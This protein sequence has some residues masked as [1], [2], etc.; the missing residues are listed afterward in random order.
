MF[1]FFAVLAGASLMALGLWMRSQGLQSQAW[2]ST[3]GTVT[4]H[5]LDESDLENMRPI[6]AYEYVVKSKHYVGWRVSYS[7]Y[8]ASKKAMQAYIAPYPLGSKVKVFYDP[9]CPGR[10]VLDNRPSQDWLFW[11]SAGVAFL[12]GA[13]FLM[14][15]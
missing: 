12:I 10:A 8:G 14:G 15:R 7:S 6:I 5:R 9:Q 3:D 13:V 4:E 1:T 2:Q 11:F